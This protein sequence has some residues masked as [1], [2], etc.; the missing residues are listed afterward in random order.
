MSINLSYIICFLALKTIVAAH[1]IILCLVLHY[2]EPLCEGFWAK[3]VLSSE[4]FINFFDNFFLSSLV[5]FIYLF[6]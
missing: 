1:L 4:I 5:Y 2:Y 3:V 6:W